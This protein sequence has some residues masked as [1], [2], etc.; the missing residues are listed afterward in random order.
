M[1][2]LQLWDWLDDVRRV[3]LLYTLMFD[4]VQ[5]FKAR[6]KVLGNTFASSRRI[7]GID[8]SPELFNKLLTKT[9]RATVEPMNTATRCFI[10]LWLDRGLL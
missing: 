1:N 10:T 4:L 8:D 7:S 5:I 2:S 6:C 3:W 9:A